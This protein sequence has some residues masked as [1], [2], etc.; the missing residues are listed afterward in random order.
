MDYAQLSIIEVVIDLLKEKGEPTA[1]NEIIKQ[2][3]EIKG[4]PADDY[5]AFAQVYTDVTTSSDFTYLGDGIFDL[6]SRQTL[7]TYDLDGSAFTK[8]VYVDEDEEDVS[9]DDYNID[10]EDEDDDDDD[11]DSE[12]DYED[13]YS[14]ED[15]D[16]DDSLDE[17]DPTDDD[18]TPDYLDEEKYNEYMDDYEDMY[19]DNN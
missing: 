2:A 18:D 11:E 15:D 17:T 12:D 1:I 3:L 9:I 13:N 14:D 19:D 6:K 16:E 5:E 8:E 10:D 7:E 4:I